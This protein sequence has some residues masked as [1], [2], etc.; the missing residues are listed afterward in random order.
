MVTGYEL[1]QSG[2]RPSNLGKILKLIS[3][4][5]KQMKTSGSKKLSDIYIRAKYAVKIIESIRCDS[6]LGHVVTDRQLSADPKFN[7]TP[8]S[9]SSKEAKLVEVR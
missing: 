2:N 8:Q 1:H 3:L 4:I 9:S 7:F 6:K 5:M